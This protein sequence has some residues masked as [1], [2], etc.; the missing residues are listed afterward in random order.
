MAPVREMAVAYAARTET[1]KLPRYWTR[2]CKEL[3]ARDPV[4][5]RSIAECPPYAT[6]TAGD[7]HGTLARAIVGQQ[8]SVAAARS[9]WL[10]LQALAT[11]FAPGAVAR[12]PHEALRSAG[13][14][15]RKVQYI[16]DLS[17]RMHDGRLDPARWRG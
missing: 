2:A 10:R 9:I 1:L 12:L 6:T 13:L 3:S 11:P 16:T 17:E 4:L 14:S 15:V 7:A 8:I 5:A